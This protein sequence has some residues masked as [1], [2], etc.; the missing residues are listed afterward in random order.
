MRSLTFVIVLVTI[1]CFFTGDLTWPNIVLGVLA[2]AVPTWLIR[3][4][5]AERRRERTKN[6]FRHPLRL[7]YLFWVFVRELVLGSIAIAK[8]LIIP[9]SRWEYAPGIIPVP[10]DTRDPVEITIFANTISMIPGTLSVD[11][12]DDSSTLYMHVLDASDPADRAGDRNGKLI[13]Y[14]K[15]SFEA[16]V[17][18]AMQQK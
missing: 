3:A 16:N 10:L 15:S 17:I 4:E 8:M 1:W 18:W 12:S 13:N 9:R 7:M 6:Y 11:V 5:L 14:V 2:A